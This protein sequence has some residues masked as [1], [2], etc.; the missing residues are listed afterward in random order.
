MS[1]IVFDNELFMAG[2]KPDLID[3]ASVT[4][5]YMGWIELGAVA[6]NV[7]N[8]RI[9][10]MEKVLNVWTREYAEGNISKTA[11]WDDRAT[12]TYAFEK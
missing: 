8:C 10:K 4:L 9:V 3:E 12:L 1:G 2:E 11:V 7:A 6:T 5:Y